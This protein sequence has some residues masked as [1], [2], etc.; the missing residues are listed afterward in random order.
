MLHCVEEIKNGVYWIGCN[1]FRT[2]LFERIFPI[3]EGVSY[4]SYFID[5]EKTVVLDTVDKT[6]RDEFVDDVQ[7]L[8]KGRKLDYLVINHM[9]PDHCG[10]IGALLQL[11]PETKIVGQ[12][13]TIKLFEQFYRQPLPH[14]YHI[15]KEGDQLVTGKHTLQFIKAPMVHWPEVMMT[16]DIT[17]K[18]LFSADAFGSFGVCGNVYADQVDYE[19]EYLDTARRYYVNIVGKYGMQVMNVLKK[20]AGIPIEIICPIHGVVFRTPEDISYILDK[21][22]HW[23]QYVPEKNGV[24]VAF[25]SIYGNTERAVDILAHKLSALGVHNVKLLDVASHHPSYFT[26]EAWKYSH[27]ILA[28]PTYNLNLFLPFD[29]ALHDLSTLLFKNRKVAILGNH[30]WSSV[31]VKEMK[32]YVENVFKGCELLE[33]P[34]DIT[35]SIAENE[36]EH[37]TRIA[38]AVAKSIKES[39]DPA[40][41]IKK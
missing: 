30:S 40:T 17:D 28:A 33:E 1:D 5:D 14:N 24:L 21:Y 25:A 16:Y 13:Q 38:E 31:A 9:E 19:H 6:C 2:P 32:N 11:H 22:L 15:V 20:A 23:A 4:N 8:L 3:P 10:C 37:L 29:A 35:S 41:L 18:I 34:L 36:D 7:Y 26:A 12:T 27:L 39:P